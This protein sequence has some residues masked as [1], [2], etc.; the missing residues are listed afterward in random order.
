MIFFMRYNDEYINFK[1]ALA[2]LF[3][4]K[5][6]KNILDISYSLNDT[7]VNIQIVLLEDIEISKI[8]QQTIDNDLRK[9]TFN[10]HEVYLTKDQYNE[11]KGE[12]N[13]KYYKWLD[14]VLFS[15]GEAL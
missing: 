11:S 1:Y 4:S 2:K 13:P 12:W 10:I 5:A 15:K 8:F 9:F 3:L 6:N 7:E 14:N